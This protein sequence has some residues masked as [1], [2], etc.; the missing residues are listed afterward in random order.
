[1]LLFI[2]LLC[3]YKNEKNPFFTLNEIQLLP[4]KLALDVSP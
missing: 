1:M 2:A 3:A 4:V